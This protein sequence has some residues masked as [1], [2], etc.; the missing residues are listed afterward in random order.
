[1]VALAKRWAMVRAGL[2][3]AACS[4]LSVK[5]LG[6]VAWAAGTAA[7]ADSEA[8]ITNGVFV[9]AAAKRYVSYACTTAEQR[10]SVTV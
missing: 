9:A 10:V 6:T 3:Q 5:A 7:E 8:A 2:G 4:M 1:M